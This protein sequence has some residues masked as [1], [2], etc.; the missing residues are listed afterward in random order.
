MKKIYILSAVALMALASCDDYDDQFNLGN[1]IT[2]VKNGTRIVL[3]S[4]DYA[5][6]AG[7]SANKEL[8]A[9]LDA[10]SGSTAYTEAL[11]KLGEQKYF[12]TLITP[13]LFLPAF[14]HTKYKEADAWSKF[15]VTYNM[16]TG[17]SHYLADFDNLKGEYT[18]T[19]ADYSTAWDGASSATYLTPK[20]VAK[21]P[22]LVKAAKKDAQEGDIIAVNYAYSEFEPAGG[23]ET[24]GESYTKIA[25][26]LANTDG[27]E[28]TVKGIVCATYSRGFLMTDDKTH[29]ILV[30]KSS[31]VKIGDEVTVA[32]TTTQ[33]G[34]LMQYPNTAEVN[35]VK[36]GKEPNYK[37]PA[38]KKMVA[39]DFESYSTTPYVAYVTYTGKLTISGSYYN[40]AID[41]TEKQGS[42]SYVQEGTVSTDLNGKDV[43]V[44]GYTVGSASKG[45]YVNTMVTSVAE[46]TAANRAKAAARAASNGGANRTMVYRYNGTDWKVYSADIATVVAAQ[47]EWYDLIGSTSVSNP[48]NYF[49]TLLQREYPFAANG[50]KVAVVYRKSSSAMAVVEYFKTATGWEQSKDYKQKTTSFV[51]TEDGFK[52]L[53]STYLEESL[54]GD[55]GGF[56]A[57]DVKRDAALSYVWTN[58]STYGW[59]ASAYTGGS[60]K[61][62]ESYLVS[63]AVNLTE[64]EAPQLKFDEAMNKLNG[65]NVADFVS[66]LVSTDFDG[67]AAA[68]TWTPLEINHTIDGTSWD[69]ASVGPVS[70]AAYAGKV[71]HIAFLYKSTTEAAGTYEVK[72][73]VVDEAE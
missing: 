39:A 53:A 14:I 73:V 32:G 20:T 41:G 2:D 7:L 55:E 59:K 44:Y 13:D 48:D 40:V 31:D 49:P 16:Y 11:E 38:P 8:A 29:Y 27:G 70:L 10:E 58:T 42:L 33:Y 52:T 28:Y 50:Q 72:N 6:I 65:F 19:A 23:G 18:L 34:G 69:F 64:A 25:D 54:L 9:K 51:Q 4:A 60:C 71:I 56:V 62:S 63:P 36:A 15:K 57:Y 47:P 24:P 26:V 37:Q 46:A 61:E 3:T 12:G 22:A 68:A 35:V 66:V 45:K 5:T 21:L 1:Q 67:D 17:K 43:V 30:Y